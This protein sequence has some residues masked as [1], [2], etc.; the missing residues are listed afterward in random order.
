MADQ[1]NIKVWQMSGDDMIR[2]IEEMVEDIDTAVSQLNFIVGERDWVETKKYARKIQ[3]LC[4]EIIGNTDFKRVG[5]H[6]KFRRSEIDD[7]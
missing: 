5:K 6:G 1:D 7:E 4:E 3:E 2:E